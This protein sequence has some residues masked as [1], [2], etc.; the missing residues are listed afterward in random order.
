MK[1]TKCG[2][3]FFT[4]YHMGIVTCLICG[5]IIEFTQ[6]AVNFSRSTVKVYS[7]DPKTTKNREKYRRH[8][9]AMQMAKEM[10]QRG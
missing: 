1:C 9:E 3:K 4:T 8:K 10:V 7:D 2:N 6:P 5:N